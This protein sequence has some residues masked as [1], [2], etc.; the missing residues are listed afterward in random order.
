MAL[1]GAL[2]RTDAPIDLDRSL[3]A[4]AL[5]QGGR[6]V[7]RAPGATLGVCDDAMLA[8]DGAMVALF[9]GRLDDAA[10][11][12][13]RSAADVVLRAYC[14]WGTDFAAR[15]VGDFACAVW[16]G[17]KGRLL[18]ARDPFAA[19]PLHF[20]RSGGGVRFATEPQGL[21]THP[22]IPRA[23]DE[24]WLARWLA[25]LP[26][27]ES[28][29]AYQGI[30]RVMP[31]HVALFER[32]EHRQIP[33][34]RPEDLPP[35]R[36]ASD[37]EYAETMRA[38]LDAA[39]RCRVAGH[40]A[41]GSTLSA[42]LDSSS[43][44][45]LAARQL[46]PRG[47]RLTSFTAVPVPGYDGAGKDARIWDE[48]PLASVVAGAEP[49]IDAV[50][51]PNGG[52]PLFDVLDG[53]AA[54]SGLP[55]M[56]P[57]N[58]VWV[59]AI[60]RAAKQRGITVM[61]GAGMGNMSISYD[62][63]GALPGLARGGQWIRLARHL[64]ALHRCGHG[65][66]ALIDRAILPALPERVRRVVRKLAG[67]PEVS[68]HDFSAMRPDFAARLGLLDQAERMAGDVSKL[69]PVAD[70]RL[71]VIRRT[72]PGMALRA[73]RRR[74]GYIPCDPT[75]DRRLVE[76]CLAIPVEQYLLHGE[77][78]SLVRRAMAGILPDAVRLETRRGLQGADWSLHVD[79]ERAGIA[80]EIA[81]LESSPLASAA[82]DLP[83]LHALLRDWPSTGWH[84][85]EI[86]TSYRLA[87]MRAVA[88]GRFLRR[89]EG[90]N[91]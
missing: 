8:T 60:G 13:G 10:G 39:V 12:E 82:I 37:A 2:Q 90:S 23:I 1:A 15:M 66:G 45:L 17:T 32:G 33:F 30:E 77:S 36:L 52:P 7:H 69:V 62:G 76:F 34:W 56:N 86:A 63:F 74:F 21:L 44:S 81:R 40:S 51:V 19:Q 67:H 55:V 25:L 85:P 72:D 46:A 68:L 59:D 53:F 16:D 79:A 5:G 27:S 75:A 91:A 65:W 61:L 9:H 26:L 24:T 73:E 84:R 88:T 43:V 87:L 54:T 48:G 89:F 78:R 50:R 28:R 64:S 31:G 71:A 80:A 83:R 70:P 35:I 47:L 20:W 22:D 6:R 58:Q 18:L 11:I 57:I 4:M 38:L 3:A 14:R 42:G 41:V 29:S 49:N